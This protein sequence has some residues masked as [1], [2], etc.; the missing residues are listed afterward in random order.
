MVTEVAGQEVDADD[1]VDGLDFTALGSD[2]DNLLSELELSV[3]GDNELIVNIDGL[4]AS[5][6]KPDAAWVGAD[7]LVFT[8]ADPGGASASV[9]AVFSVKNT[10]SGVQELTLPDEFALHQ[11]Y[12]NPFNPQTTIAFDLKQSGE[13]KL[14]IYDITGRMVTKL[15][16]NFVQ[17][18]RHKIVWDA[19]NV[20]TGTYLIV[21]QVTAEQ[22][23]VFREQRKMLLIR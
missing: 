2:I 17:A 10:A 5:I 18:G 14:T 1:G 15:V 21:I 11:N 23:N 4:T 22:K 7:T 19:T 8:V 12:P 16:D 6:T 3:A 9:S 20:A 13:V